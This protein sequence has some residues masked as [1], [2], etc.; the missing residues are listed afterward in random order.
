MIASLYPLHGDAKVVITQQYP[1]GGPTQIPFNIWIDPSEVLVNTN[2]G[3]VPDAT[4]TLYRADMARAIRHPGIG[5]RSHVPWQSCQ[6]N[7]DKY[8][9]SFL[10]GM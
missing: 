3:P 10:A 8:R 7:A 6:F 2:G 1:D 9:R 5:Q 4:V